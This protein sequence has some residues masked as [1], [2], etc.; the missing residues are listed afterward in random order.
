MAIVDEITAI[1]LQAGISNSLDG[2]LGAAFEV[3]DDLNQNNDVAAVNA[4][5]AFINSVSAQQGNQISTDDATD[6][7]A[8]AQA[9]IDLLTAP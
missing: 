2:K 3:L 7:I 4:L 1:N 8:A 5:E 6:L 9:V